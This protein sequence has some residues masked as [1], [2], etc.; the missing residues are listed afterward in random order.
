ME[1]RNHQ[2]FAPLMQRCLSEHPL[3]RGKFEDV[4][5]DLSVHQSKYGGKQAQMM[6]DQMVR[7][8]L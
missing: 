4:G 2:V 3:A 5:K 7:H 8:L 6:E 1:G